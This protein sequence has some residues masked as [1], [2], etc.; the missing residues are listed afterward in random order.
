[1]FCSNCGTADE[2]GRFCSSCGFQNKGEPQTAA[3]HVPYVNKINKTELSAA[4]SE[5][6]AAV[7]KGSSVTGFVLSLVGAVF[8]SAPIICLPLAITGLVLS[9]KRLNQLGSQRS[10]QGLAKA[11]LI[12]GSIAAGLTTLFMLLAI[13]GAVE[14]NF[15]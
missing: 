14:H 8:V 6:L 2:D 9:K 1:M 12:I 13:P 5:K 4:A 3:K 15:G 11:G 10:G 7:N